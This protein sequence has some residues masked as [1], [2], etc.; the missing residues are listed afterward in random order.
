MYALPKSHDLRRSFIANSQRQALAMRLRPENHARRIKQELKQAGVSRIG[1]HLM[2]SRFLPH[3]IHGNE[4]I[5]GAVYGHHDQG[6][7]MVVAT[8]QRLIFLDKK[9]LFIDE[10]QISYDV[11][12]GV[13][14]SEAGFGATVTVHTRVKDFKIKA[15]NQRAAHRFVR[16]LEQK[17]HHLQR[18]DTRSYER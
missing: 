12:A 2:E 14:Y 1:L 6:T 8:D 10:D 4:H 7:V 9:P 5:G 18:E 16:Y 17:C 13:D 15:L 3:I 11:V